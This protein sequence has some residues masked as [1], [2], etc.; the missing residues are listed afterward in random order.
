MNSANSSDLPVEVL[1]YSGA[2][3][4]RRD[5]VWR[6]M[7]VAGWLYPVCWVG[8]MCLVWGA[9]W[10]TLGHPPRSSVDD[11]KSIGRVVDFFYLFAALFLFTWPVGMTTGI[12]VGIAATHHRVRRRGGGDGV[13]VLMWAAL[14]ALYLGAL[15]FFLI[16]PMHMVEWFLD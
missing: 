8:S 3:G 12:A 13:M 16:D 2:G 1:A 9:A 11:P 15:W 5:F 10:V 6:A 4:R 14:C 7:F